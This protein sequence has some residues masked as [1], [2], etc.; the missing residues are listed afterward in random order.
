[1]I[2]EQGNGLMMFVES[3]RK[4]TRLP[5]PDKKAIRFEDLINRI[6]VLYSS[7]ENSDKVKLIV[8]AS[9][10]GMELLADENQI[11]QV[12]INLVKNALQANEKNI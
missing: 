8:L 2:K 5:M 4:L 6:K 1:V 11:S 10:P 9:P 3:Y 7:L 12:L